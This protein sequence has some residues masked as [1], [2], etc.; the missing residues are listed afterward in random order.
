MVRRLL[1]RGVEAG[2]AML[3]SGSGP[4]LAAVHGIQTMRRRFQPAEIAMAAPV[5]E[6]QIRGARELEARV[7][8]LALAAAILL[9][10]IYG[11]R[12]QIARAAVLY[13]ATPTAQSINSCGT[14]CTIP[15]EGWQ[16]PGLLEWQGRYGHYP[17]C[18]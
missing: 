13:G 4:Y 12:D 15:Q 2:R 14:S 3:E 5:L 7:L 11:V 9:A 17:E 10:T 8:D 1:V 6:P 18:S 16:L